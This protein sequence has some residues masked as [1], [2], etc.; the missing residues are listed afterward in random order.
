[1]MVSGGGGGCF[2]MCEVPLYAALHQSRKK[3]LH[4]IHAKR[5]WMLKAEGKLQEG[6]HVGCGGEFAI[7]HGGEAE[8]DES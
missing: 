4:T 2:F 3:K 8:L 1:M 7:R 5:G 6:V